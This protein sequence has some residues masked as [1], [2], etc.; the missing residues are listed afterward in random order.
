MAS[1]LRVANSAAIVEDAVIQEMATLLATVTSNV[2][3]RPSR[4]LGLALNRRALSV[5]PG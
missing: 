2:A 1:F 4:H 3:L 5:E